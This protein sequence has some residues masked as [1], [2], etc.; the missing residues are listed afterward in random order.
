MEDIYLIV[1][2]IAMVGPSLI[3]AKETKRRLLNLKSGAKA[4]IFL[5]LTVGLLMIYVIFAKD[6]VSKIPLLNL[7]WLGYNISLGPFGNEGLFGILPFLPMLVYTLIHVNYFEEFYFR[8]NI[9]RVILWAF[10]HVAMGVAIHVALV[11][12]PLGF[13]YRSI[14]N[15]YS[16][17]HAYALHLA[18]NLVLIGISLGSYFLLQSGS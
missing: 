7:S 10:L 11:L 13:F 6:L 16:I 15:K 3:L 5:P 14:Y 2:Y 4:L 18:T 8:K 1:I 12:L 9:K 17:N